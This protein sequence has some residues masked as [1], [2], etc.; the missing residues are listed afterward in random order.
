MKKHPQ[1]SICETAN[2]LECLECGTGDKGNAVARGQGV[3]CW[4]AIRLQSLAMLSKRVR[5]IDF[6]FVVT[7]SFWYSN[8]STYKTG[9]LISNACPIACICTL[10]FSRLLVLNS[11][12]CGGDFLRLLYICL[13]QWA[14][15][16][17]IFLFLVVA[18]SFPSRKV[19]L[20]LVV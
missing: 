20:I 14:F 18:S 19:P 16:F 4:A 8:L 9:L 1:S 3:E 15:P 2:S 17:I 12:L 6:W 10:L 7:I 13:Y 5:L 11:Y